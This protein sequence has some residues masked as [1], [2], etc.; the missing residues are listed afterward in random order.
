MMSP[1]PLQDTEP[2][3]AES[4]QTGRPGFSLISLFKL[5]TPGASRLFCQAI[6]LL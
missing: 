2:T 6:H 5:E 1:P 3:A 4:P